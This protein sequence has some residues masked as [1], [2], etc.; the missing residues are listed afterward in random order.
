MKRLGGAGSK[1]GLVGW[2]YIDRY[3]PGGITIRW[4]RGDPVAYVLPGNKLG[5]HSMAG[6]LATIPVPPAG[7]S[8][9]SD[10]RQLAHRWHQ[11]QA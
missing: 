10:I 2:A 5:D 1:T 3:R 7:W 4:R 6:V 8:D 9:H 11:A